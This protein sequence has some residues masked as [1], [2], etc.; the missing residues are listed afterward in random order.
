MATP[1]LN[2]KWKIQAF[3]LDSTDILLPKDFILR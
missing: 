1:L 2:R 3:I